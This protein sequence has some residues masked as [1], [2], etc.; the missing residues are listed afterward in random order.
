L[1]PNPNLTS[2]GAR[3]VMPTACYGVDALGTAY[4]MDGIPLRL[5]AVLDRQRPTDEEVLDR[6]IEVVQAC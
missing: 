5:R 4:R 1:D 2:N 3:V 6:I